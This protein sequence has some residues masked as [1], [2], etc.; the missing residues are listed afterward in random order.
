MRLASGISTALRRY[1]KASRPDRSQVS[2]SVPARSKL[3][4]LG[5]YLQMSGASIFASDK[6]NSSPHGEGSDKVYDNGDGLK[7]LISVIHS[8]TARPVEKLLISQNESEVKTAVVIAALIYGTSRGPGNVRSV[9]IPDIAKYTLKTGNGFRV[10]KGE[11]AWSNVSVEDVG[12]L[13]TRLVKAAVE[14]KEGLW[15]DIGVYLPES[16][17][18]VSAITGLE[19]LLTRAVFW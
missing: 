14:G 5:H 12:R 17:Q 8:N 4:V 16:G 2:C 10:G 1:S 19:V 11:S 13:F 7:D 9:Q 15:N 6:S 3:D 18:M